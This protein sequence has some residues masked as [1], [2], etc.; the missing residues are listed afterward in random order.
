MKF[1]PEKKY[2]TIAI[3]AFIVLAAAIIFSE[4]V[5]LPKVFRF[6]NLLK[7]VLSPV[8]IGFALAYFK[9]INKSF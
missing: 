5:K 6:F 8:I 9:S 3:Y 2:T 7:T 1:I 4:L